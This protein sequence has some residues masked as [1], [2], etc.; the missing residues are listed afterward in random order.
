MHCLSPLPGPLQMATGPGST[1]AQGGL[2]WSQTD[3]RTCLSTAGKD[4]PV[5]RD[6]REGV[7]QAP[8]HSRTV[9]CQVAGWQ[10]LPAG[11]REHLPLWVL[12]RSKRMSGSKGIAVSSSGDC[13]AP[14][15]PRNVEPLRGPRMGTVG[16]HR[17][18]WESEAGLIQTTVVTIAPASPGPSYLMCTP[19]SVP[20]GHLP[21]SGSR[22]E[23]RCDQGPPGPWA[24]ASSQEGLGDSFQEKQEEELGSRKN[25]RRYGCHFQTH[26]RRRTV[27]VGPRRRG[28]GLPGGQLPFPSKR[29]AECAGGGG[30]R[31]GVS[32][33]NLSSGGRVPGT[34]DRLAAPAF[35]CALG[36]P[37]SARSPARPALPD[38]TWP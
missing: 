32:L 22:L 21:I 16:L 8:V 30:L 17:L 14:G 12:R 36:E 3:P 38:Q 20:A 19:H 9:P 13:P 37:G 35:L 26:R 34:A 25:Q 11:P 31:L 5:C 18:G 33:L 4:S 2:V 6:W 7:S 15:C 1:A 24:E 27:S 23:G 10:V 29:P 28:G